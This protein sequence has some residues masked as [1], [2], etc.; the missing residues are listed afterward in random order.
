[1]KNF[2]RASLGLAALSVLAACQSG[3]VPSAQLPAIPVTGS[4]I[5][6]ASVNDEGGYLEGQVQIRFAEGVDVQDFV[7]KQSRM[8][9]I[10]LAAISKINGRS[11]YLFKFE[12]TL[13]M[14]KMLETLKAD[15]RVVGAA[16]NYPIQI[17]AMDPDYSMQWSLHNSGQ[18]APHALSGRVGADIGFD[19]N[20]DTGSNDVVVAI[21]DTGIDYYHEDLAVTEVVDG[22]R[23]IVSGNIWMNPEE[24][25]GNGLNDDNNYSDEINFVD[26][27]YGY[28]FVDLN[29]DP[30]DDHGHGTH[31]AGVI[32]A[33]RNNF[34]GIKG[35]NSQVK[36]M[37][38]KFLSANG[39][40]SDWSGI[41]GIYYVVDMAKRFPEK[42]FI[43]N[44]SWGGNGRNSVN[45]DAD[46]FMLA[47]FKE[48]DE[49]NIF[50][51]VAAGN[52]ALSNEF[53]DFYPANYSTKLSSMVTVAATNNLDQL[54]SFSNYG[55]Q[56]VQVAAPGVLIQSTLPGNT[57]AAWSGT[58]MATPHVAG[59]AAAIWATNLDMT[60]LD[61]K[62]RLLAT[63]D[64]LP[65]L[66]GYVTSAGR[67]NMARALVGDE[68]VALTPV[69][70]EIQKQVRSP[71]I[72]SGNWVDYTTEI[73]EE[74]A[75]SISVCFESIDLK[76]SGDWIQVYGSDYRVRDI[77]Q[78]THRNRNLY[79][80]ERMPV[81]TAP[82][83]GDVIY[84]RMST[85][86]AIDLGG[87]AINLGSSSSNFVTESVRVE[88]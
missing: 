82:V 63:V 23:Q 10:N 83:P 51:A 56:K 69:I 40:G 50:V 43:M 9:Q 14:K 7:L 44:C 8:N 79:T 67:I 6:S 36:M 87:F 13:P 19:P 20:L 62:E 26:D 5:N 46:D 71:K 80:G 68:T 53:A 2:F 31:I 28:N 25:P 66:K 54:A 75:K 32:G 21:V 58:S 47:A 42:R 27:V 72:P 30:M 15:E 1:M 88:R 61:V 49:N 86:G 33:L 12:S 45:G 81:C 70:E 11:I 64:V 52:S 65:Q 4:E 35:M 29:G 57:Y 3:V 78:G 16:P 60:A 84:L 48:A 74:G 85:M 22:S 34:K 24:I 17:N 37:G 38:V 41:Q 55:N 73:R 76:S 18:E 59:L 39:G 77:I